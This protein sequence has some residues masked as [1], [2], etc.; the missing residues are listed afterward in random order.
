MPEQLGKQTSGT[1]PAARDKS[2][3]TSVRTKRPRQGPGS[4]G[5][6]AGQ[7]AGYTAGE[8]K[9]ANSKHLLDLLWTQS[10]GLFPSGAAF[11][12]QIFSLCEQAVLVSPCLPGSLTLRDHG[13]L[14]QPGGSTSVGWAGPASAQSCLLDSWHW[15]SPISVGGIVQRNL[16]TLS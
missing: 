2:G 1:S 5:Q 10:Q 3:L 12:T 7:R 16:H 15:L 6:A 4:P 13:V 9:P 11:Q 14:E 8:A